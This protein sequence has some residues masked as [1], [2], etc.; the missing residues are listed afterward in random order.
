LSAN[1]KVLA[2]AG[3]RTE[4][5]AVVFC[6]EDLSDSE[7]RREMRETV[8]LLVS[9]RKKKGNKG[10]GDESSCK[11]ERESL[12]CFEAAGS[13]SSRGK[14]K[15][16]KPRRPFKTALGTQGASRK[17]ANRIRGLSGGG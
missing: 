1:S 17:R 14:E 4:S 10:R 5:R 3:H 11:R 9:G 16:G 13:S 8:Q 7:K 12:P 2:I 6:G 15:E